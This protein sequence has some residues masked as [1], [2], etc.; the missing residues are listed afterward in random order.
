MIDDYMVKP[1]QGAIFRKFIDQIIGV[2]PAA[3]TVPV[4]VR[5]EHLRNS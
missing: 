5:V 4:K 2:I 3:D 1:L